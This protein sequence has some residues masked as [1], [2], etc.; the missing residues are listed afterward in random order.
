MVT[1][2]DL[3]EMDRVRVRDHNRLASEVSVLKQQCIRREHQ[4]FM[5]TMK[6]IISHSYNSANVHFNVVV[7]AG[8]VGF[9]ALWGS[10]KEDVPAWSILPSGALILVS[11][12]I[13]IAFEVWKS[14]SVGSGMRGV[15]KRLKGMEGA[16]SVEDAW[17]LRVEITEILNRSALRQARVWVF[18][19]IPCVST[20]LLAGIILAGGFLVEFYSSYV[21]EILAVMID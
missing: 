14:I 12:S 2:R 9:F 18:V 20:G 16:D 1:R 6:E 21:S 17:R 7:A 15:S 4:E 5:D 11:L 3:E 8:Y 10:V 19:T 13:F